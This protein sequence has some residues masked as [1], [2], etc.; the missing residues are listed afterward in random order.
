M[1]Q[2][3]MKQNVG[4][5][6]TNK[7]GTIA[8][9]LLKGADGSFSGFLIRLKNKTFEIWDESTLVALPRHLGSTSS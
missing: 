2:L 6:K 1:S 9:G 7:V 3:K 8:S 5:Y 4:N